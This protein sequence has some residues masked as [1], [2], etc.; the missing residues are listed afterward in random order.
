VFVE[1]PLDVFRATGQFSMLLQM[2]GDLIEAQRGIFDMLDQYPDGSLCAQG[3][4]GVGP[5]TEQSLLA[6]LAVELG[7]LAQVTKLA[8]DFNSIQ[9]AGLMQAR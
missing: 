2:G 9:L 3:A 7:L 1:E 4:R 6:L 5:L 8:G